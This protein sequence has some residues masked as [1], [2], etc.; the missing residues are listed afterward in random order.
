MPKLLSQVFVLG[1]TYMALSV[2][3][4]HE[5]NILGQPPPEKYL[6]TIPSKYANSNCGCLVL[7]LEQKHVLNTLALS[8]QEIIIYKSKGIGVKR[9]EMESLLYFLH[10]SISYIPY[11]IHW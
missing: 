5:H 7:G 8:P 1:M 6:L 2:E 10:G 3:H 9:L 11:H 4:R